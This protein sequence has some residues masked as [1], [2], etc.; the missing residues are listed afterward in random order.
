VVNFTFENKVPVP[1][2]A[3]FKFITFPLGALKLIKRLVIPTGFVKFN[4]TSISIGFLSE[5]L[6]TYILDLKKF[7]E[8][9]LIS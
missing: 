5:V 9:W 3:L 1:E 8:F 2:L 4:L 6:L 7:L